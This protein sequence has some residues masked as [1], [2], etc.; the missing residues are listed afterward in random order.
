MTTRLIQGLARILLTCLCA[1]SAAQAGSIGL[2]WNAVPNAT[3]Y[4]VYYGNA[5]GHYTA[6]KD[7]GSATSVALAGLTDCTNWYVAV[8]AYNAMG[9]SAA[10]SE[11]VT[12]WS[13]PSIDVPAPAAAMQGAQLDIQLHGA[14]FKPG[15]RVTIDNPRVRLV[16]TVVV[17]C[18][19]IDLEAELEPGGAG[20]RPAQVGLFTLTIDNP[21]GTFGER[22]DGFEVKLNPARFDVNRS[23]DSTRD[24]LDG[25]D[26][27][28]LARLFSSHEGDDALYDGDFDFDGDGWIDGVDLNL[29]A[30]NFGA[31][32]SGTA[33]TTQACSAA[34]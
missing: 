3:G 20:I 17:D 2:A 12:G 28:W 5:S 1:V 32:W 10:F 16:S 14:N 8:K 15:A 18:G 24:R 19:R 34:R 31:C 13:R 29:V 11:E 9:E 6:S 21:D 33:W 7:V 4:R 26:T 27:V 25:A 22:V 30:S 23:N